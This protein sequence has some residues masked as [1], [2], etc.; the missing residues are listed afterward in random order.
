MVNIGI[1]GIGFMGV[2][3]YKAIQ[4]IQNAQVSAICTRNPKKLS[5]DWRDVKG[6]FGDSGGVQDLSG[7]NKYS[8]VDDII[9]DS[10]VDLID[11]CL[12]TDLHCDATIGALEGGKHVLL[13]KP[14]TINLNDADSMV[15]AAQKSGKKFIVAQV[16]RFFPE[17]AL[18]KKIVD[19]KG[20]G[21]LLGAHFKRIISRPD[22]IQDVE[23]PIGSGRA[24][25]AG[26]DLHIHDSDFVRYLLG[27]PNSV[28]S[29]G[30][31]TNEDSVDYLVTNYIYK[32]QD[33]T[34][35]SQ[36]GWIAMPGVLFEHGYDVYLE[37]ATLRFN[38]S[39]QPLTL[40]TADGK[41]CTPETP[42][43]DGFI[44]E[45]RY[46]V[47]CVLNN[48]DPEI[49]SGKSARDS[50]YLCLKEMESV[51]SGVEVRI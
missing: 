20:Y 49:L 42:T 30:L 10:D 8:K 11:I 31:M 33:V 26:I 12:P 36:C 18:A 3:H 21:K 5:G 32:D 16:L 39:G 41:E 28:S 47:D 37:D 1:I 51:A 50:L 35:T 4:E 9:N 24:G 22:W 29:A 46:A 38:S 25:G 2:T 15:E 45:I 13:E 7:I 40:F 23:S 34:I 44:A 48:K 14:I 19:S 17:F 43:D 27:M 6:N